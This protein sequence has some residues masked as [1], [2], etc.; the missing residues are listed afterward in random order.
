VS[1]AEATLPL[2][3]AVLGCGV[4][5]RTHAR[6]LRRFPRV[7][8]A[9]ASRERSRAEQFA[10]SLGGF[11]AFGSYEAAIADPSV[12]AVLITTPPN[13]HL[14]LTLA[15]LTAG[16]HVLVEKPAFHSAAEADQAHAAMER[17][18][19]AVLVLENYCYK[20]LTMLARRLIAAGEIGE[21]RYVRVNALKWQARSGW[22]AE[23]GTGGGG[24]LYE[25]GVHWINFLA[26]IGPPIESIQGFA[27]PTSGSQEWSILAV[28]R[29][30]GGAI[31]TLHHAWDAPVRLKGLSLSQIIGSRGTMLFESNGIFLALNGVRRR[32]FFPGFRDI[33]GYHAMF[34][35][36]ITVLTQGGNPLMTLARARADLALVEEA[37]RTAGLPEVRS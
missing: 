30:A 21:L 9:F 25:G 14:R 36:F 35:D 33:R 29:Y 19:R 34:R 24:A 3:I 27:P 1:P 6:T 2:R 8:Y 28:A 18:G 10:S 23:P 31:A 13:E 32:L 17:A 37:Y 15:A 16:K 12:D 22:R 4:V 5:A 26:M 11:G 20:P 7:R